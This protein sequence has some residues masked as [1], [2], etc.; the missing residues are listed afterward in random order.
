MT[1]DEVKE[2]VENNPDFEVVGDCSY[3][4][5]SAKNPN[6]LNGLLSLKD[7]I[8]PVEDVLSVKPIYLKD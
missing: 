1:N 5:I 8:D 2:Y 6:I 7:I 4:E 3:I